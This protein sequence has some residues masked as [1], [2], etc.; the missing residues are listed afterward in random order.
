MLAPARPIGPVRFRFA[1]L[2][3]FSVLASYAVLLNLGEFF[4]EGRANWSA[5][6]YVEY[7]G[8]SDA[9]SYLRLGIDLANFTVTP[10]NYWIVGLWPPG[11]AVIDAFAIMLP[12]SLFVWMM[13]INVTALALPVALALSLA[14][15]KR[16]FLWIGGL[17]LL[18]VAQPSKSWTL[19]EGLFMADGIG[20]SLLLSSLLLSQKALSEFRHNKDYRKM[21]LLFTLSGILLSASMHFRFSVWPVALVLLVLAGVV[22]GLSFGKNS[23][24][25]VLEFTRPGLSAFVI[26]FLIASTPWTLFVSTVL[27]PGNPTWSTSDY[28]WAQKWM[29]DQHLLEAGAGWLVAGGANWACS[30]DRDL[31]ESLQPKVLSGDGEHY[32]SLRNLAL[33]TGISNPL[34]LLAF[35]VPI[36]AKATVALPGGTLE[37]SLSPFAVMVFVIIITVLVASFFQLRKSLGFVYS[38]VIFSIF[39]VLTVAHVEIRYMLPIFDLFI[40]GVLL[41]LGLPKRQVKIIKRTKE[42]G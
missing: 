3:T 34:E 9:G 6:Q 16:D 36:F 11:M 27:H 37:G 20:S 38:I 32:S 12:G 30:I 23:L 14:N 33:E 40:L 15:S 18:F 7:F 13:I 31:C 10:P 39:A 28:A 25:K 8:L 4:V 5:E 21:L 2:V 42:A 24:G 35:K 26:A 19:T 17:S 22:V 41:N 1:Y 29:T